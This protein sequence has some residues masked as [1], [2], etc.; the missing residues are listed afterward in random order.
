MFENVEVPEGGF[1]TILADPPWKFKV[2]SDK[3]M[4]RSA[5][6]HYPCMSI[7]EIAAM[8]VKTMAAK[9]C[10]LLMWVTDPFL[11]LGMDVIKSWGFKF[12][13]VGFQWAKLHPKQASQMFMTEADFHMGTGYWSRANVEMCLLATRGHPKRLPT[14]TSVRRLI[15]AARREHSRKPDISYT[16]IEALVGGPYLELF[17]RSD[18]AGWT[19]WGKDKAKFGVA[20]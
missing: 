9:D 11:A 19:S 1:S 14:G 4:S 18:R 6:N 7:P 12:K 2:R 16:R 8:P 20:A 10:T 15:I 5:E 3:G 17:S 13:T